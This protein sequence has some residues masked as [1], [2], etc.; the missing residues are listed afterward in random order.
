MAAV[1]QLIKVRFFADK[2]QPGKGG[3]GLACRSMET[4]I[5]APP[6]CSHCGE[7][8]P[9]DRIRMEDNLLN[10]NIRVNK[11]GFG[12]GAVYK[13]FDRNTTIMIT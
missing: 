13:N 4:I 7:V 1:R 3:A 10:K 5:A 11:G 12:V 6:V 8:C 9:T 2:G